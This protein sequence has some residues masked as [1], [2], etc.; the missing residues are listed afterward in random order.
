[1]CVCVCVCARARA[2]VCV[3]ACA[4]VRACACVCVCVCVWGGVAFRGSFHLTTIA[5][6]FLTLLRLACGRSGG[7]RHFSDNFFLINPLFVTICPET[8]SNLCVDSVRD[9]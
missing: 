2:C 8:F 3:C 1:V 6:R 7:N 4:C 9:M 5:C